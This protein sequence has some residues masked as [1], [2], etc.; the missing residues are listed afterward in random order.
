MYKFTVH[1][2]TFEPTFLACG[3]QLKVRTLLVVNIQGLLPAPWA[4][5]ASD[6]IHH[7]QDLYTYTAI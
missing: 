5:V 6:L 7:Y 4:H 1:E 3:S 2:E